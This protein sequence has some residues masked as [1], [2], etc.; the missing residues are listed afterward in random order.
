MCLRLLRT[1]ENCTA[2]TRVCVCVCVCVRVHVRV[3]VCVCVCVCVYSRPTCKHSVVALT[4]GT[5]KKNCTLTVKREAAVTPTVLSIQ[6]CGI[7]VFIYRYSRALSPYLYI[8]TVVHY[9]RIYIS[10]QS[11]SITVFIY[12]YSR[13]VSS[14]LYIDTVVQYHRI[15]ISIQSCSITVFIYRYSCAVSPY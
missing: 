7:T 13:A 1:K 2:R 5:V 4:Q 12:R 8:D 15:Y 11:C 14:Y 3:C 10:I 6:S 9:H